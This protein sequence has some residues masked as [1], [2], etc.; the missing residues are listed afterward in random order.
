[1]SKAAKSFFYSRGTSQYHYRFHH[2]GRIAENLKDGQGS[3]GN[4]S[5][6]KSIDWEKITQPYTSFQQYA[7]RRSVVYGTKG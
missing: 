5:T 1:M 2:Q 7:S 3:S 6:M 4:M